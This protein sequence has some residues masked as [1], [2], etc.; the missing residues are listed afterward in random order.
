[1]WRN[2]WSILVL[3]GAL[4]SPPAAVSQSDVEEAKRLHD[5]AYA[6]YQK[7]DYDKALECFRAIL[8]RSE[9][10]GVVKKGNILYD[11]ACVQ[12]LKGQKAEALESL[13]RAFAEGYS[14]REHAKKDEDLESLRDDPAFLEIIGESQP[15]PKAEGFEAIELG[16]RYKTIDG[17]DFDWSTVEKKVVALV[18]GGSWHS[19]FKKAAPFLVGFHEKHKGKDFAIVSL[20]FELLPIDEDNIADAKQFRDEFQVTWPMLYAGDYD[21][22]GA[23]LPQLKPDLHNKH[24]LVVLFD[25][26]GKAR[27]FL[28]GT[29]DEAA[30][31]KG[32]EALL[33]EAR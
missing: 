21:R 15:A 26:K 6:A 5:A 9:V 29:L 7:K 22:M 20:Q 10:A 3:V 27:Q 25:W 19:Q 18:I 32:V 2:A 13:R 1:M 33:A 31:A 28:S 30:F 17:D 14:N 24:P 16:F 12:A 8:D 11:I 4:A 23:A